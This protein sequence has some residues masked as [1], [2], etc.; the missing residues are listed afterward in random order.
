MSEDPAQDGLNWYVYC[1]NNP[2]ML[3]D[4]FGLDYIPLRENAENDGFGV[5][6][7][8]ETLSASVW[9]DSNHIVGIFTVGVGNNAP[10]INSDGKMM[11]WDEQYY[12]STLLTD[13]DKKLE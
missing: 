11:V 7:N 2:V 6:W 9:R 3:I 13:Y 5:S 8:G 1:G 10:Y 12:S 4:P